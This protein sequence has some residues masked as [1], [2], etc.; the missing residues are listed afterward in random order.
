MRAALECAS[1]VLTLI[2][3]IACHTRLELSGDV[4]VSV[5]Q[6]LTHTLY[7]HVCISNMPGDFDYMCTSILCMHT[8]HAFECDEKLFTRV[9]TND[10]VRSNVYG[11][12]V[13]SSKQGSSPSAPKL[14]YMRNS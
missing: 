2:C 8:L 14:A 4:H 11:A 1:S 6:C 9:I 7:I 5:S 13:M 12:G 10:N 3:T